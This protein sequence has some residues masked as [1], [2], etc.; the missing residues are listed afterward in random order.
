MK[1]EER[2]D[3]FLIAEHELIERVMA[4]LKSNLLQMDNK[5]E[6]IIQIKR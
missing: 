2:W 5:S 3:D 1:I 6:D 4:V